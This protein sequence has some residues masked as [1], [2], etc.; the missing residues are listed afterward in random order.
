MYELF[1][2]HIYCSRPSSWLLQIWT[3]L[4][5]SLSVRVNQGLSTYNLI[6][7][8]MLLYR[9]TRPMLSQKVSCNIFVVLAKN[10]P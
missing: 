4:N 2:L 7:T 9:S 5:R 1:Y 3:V 6:T 8:Y 10:L